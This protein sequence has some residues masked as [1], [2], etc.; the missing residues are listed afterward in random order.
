MNQAFHLYRLQQIDTQIDHTVSGLEEVAKLLAGDETVQQAQHM[1][2][3]TART[4]HQAAQNLKKMEFA[5][6]EQQLKIAQS[7]AM[8]Y[9]GKVKNP[10]ELQDLQK[11]IV[12]LKKH[13]GTLEDQQLEAMLAQEESDERHNGCQAALIQAQAAF[14]EHSAGWLGQKDQLEHNLERLQTERLTAVSPVSGPDLKTY[15]SIRKRK[16]GVAVTSV[17]EGSCAV[18]GATIRPSELQAA[19]SAQDLVYCSTCGRILYSG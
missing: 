13:L 12:S 4:L 1:V 3:E 7:E 14:A 10:K 9:S 19:R 18:C 11:E 2:E 5:V 6:R 8:L 17:R 15:E 16:S